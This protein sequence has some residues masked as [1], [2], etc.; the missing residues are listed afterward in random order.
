[1]QDLDFVAAGPIL[2]DMNCETCHTPTCESCGGCKCPGNDCLCKDI[3]E[4]SDEA[5]AA[6]GLE[7]TEV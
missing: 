4:K 1:M 5:G 7:D 2:M 3:F 6:A